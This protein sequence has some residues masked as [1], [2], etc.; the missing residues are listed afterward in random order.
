MTVVNA[1]RFNDK[2]G[3]MVADSQGSSHLRKY[4]FFEKV[5]PLVTKNGTSGLLGGSGVSELLVQVQTQLDHYLAGK[6]F[7]VSDI[8]C[9]VSDIMTSI[10][11]HYV[12]RHLKATFGVDAQQALSGQNIGQ[13]LLGPITELL[14]CQRKDLQEFFSNS[15]LLLGMDT[16]GL[17]LYTIPMTTGTPLISSIPYATIGSGSDASDH[18]LAQRLTRLKREKRS[19]LTLVEGMTALLSATNTSADLNPGVGGV[20]TVAY[21]RNDKIVTLGEDASR[22]ASELV[23]LY[24]AHLLQGETPLAPLEQLLIEATPLQALEESTFEKAPNYRE[25]MHFLRGYK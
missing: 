25:L 9:A 6:E 8:A 20:P 21:F 24:D 23:R 5:R 19:R 16:Q 1:M 7:S 3:G 2:E 12:D 22:F 14:S 17:Q 18:V 15:F 10:K 13:H 11:R 4:D